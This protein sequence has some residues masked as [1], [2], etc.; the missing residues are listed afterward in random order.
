MRRYTSAEMRPP[1]H[2]PSSFWL[3]RS[4]D[5]RKRCDNLRRLRHSPRTDRTAR[6]PARTRADEV[7]SLFF[8]CPEVSLDHRVRPHPLV[9]GRRQQ[10]R[11]SR[12]H[13]Q[14]SNNVIGQSCGDS[15]ND[16][17]RRRG[18]EDCVGSVGQANVLDIR[19]FRAPKTCD[20][21]SA[22]E[23]LECSR[24]YEFS[25]G[26]GHGDGYAGAGLNEP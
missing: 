26:A 19:W 3:V 13:H 24:S 14:G 7:K 5:W 20:D 9:H 4:E 8:E 23:G 10:N 25:R 21:R 17:R 16:V 11:R 22:G 12:T 2:P 1:L 18:D 6:H 15:P